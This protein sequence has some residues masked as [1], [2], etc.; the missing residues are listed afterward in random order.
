VLGLR[1][2][3]FSVLYDILL[4]GRMNVM[5]RSVSCMIITE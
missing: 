5:W 3:A 2:A 4:S 1:D